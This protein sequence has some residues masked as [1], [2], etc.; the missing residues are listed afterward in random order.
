MICPYLDYFNIYPIRYVFC[1]ILKR[2]EIKIP[3][4][5]ILLIY[6]TIFITLSTEAA[7]SFI[8]PDKDALDSHEF[9]TRVTPAKPLKKRISMVLVGL[10]LL[11]PYTK[12]KANVQHLS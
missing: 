1:K 6:Y 10:F 5:R 7:R 3:R 8:H 9:S 11:E 12:T 2:D 4:R